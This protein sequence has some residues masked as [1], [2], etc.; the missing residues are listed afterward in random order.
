MG[1]KHYI[2]SSWEASGSP[3]G[4]HFS[5]KLKPWRQDK[6]TNW[7]RKH[8]QAWVPSYLALLWFLNDETKRFLDAFQL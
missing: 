3:P 8:S 5:L 4:V 2:C 6:Q 1:E 7:T